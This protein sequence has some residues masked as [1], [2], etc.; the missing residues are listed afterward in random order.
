[1]K[2]MTL[3]A[4]LLMTAGVMAQ[5]DLTPSSR[6]QAFGKR[7]FRD[8]ATKGLQFQIGGTYFLTQLNNESVGVSTPVEGFR[9]DFTRDPKGRLGVYGEIG[10][11]HLPKRSWK[12]RL[13]KKPEPKYLVLVSYWDWGV[14]FKYFRGTENIEM[15][16]TDQFG[17]SIGTETDAFNFSNGNIYG[18]AALHRTIGIKS[19][20]SY[21]A[22]KFFLD[23]SLGINID[24]RLLTTS[25]EYNTGYSFMTSEQRYSKPLQVQL[26][27]GL[28]FWFT[29]KRGSYLIPGVR[30]PLF[31]FQSSVTQ[32]GSNDDS[33]THF[34]KPSAHWF[35]S[36]YWPML[37][38]IK[39]MFAFEKN[40]KSK[41]PP[42]D[43]NDEDR[44]R[45]EEFMQGN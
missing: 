5:R 7:D 14:G 41:C 19:R 24:Y 31:G 6:D 43:V 27:Y 17:T 26:H 25:D 20:K 10:M 45:N 3:C 40:R 36:R 8:L 35:S 44:K 39:Y 15:N 23:N 1:M 33:R 9:G 22:P 4:V 12:I 30:I 13:K 11:W 21:G 2:W 16:L 37:F 32:V 29:L 28:G 18:R 42:V 34:E 38:H